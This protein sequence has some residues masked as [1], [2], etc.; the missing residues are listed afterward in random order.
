MRSSYGSVKPERAFTAEM[1]EELTAPF[2]LT[3]NLKLAALVDCPE[4]A[5]TPLMSL[6]FTEREL[7][8]S[9]IRNPIDTGGGL[10]AVNAELSITLDVSR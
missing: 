10:T 8:T 1:S 3:S 5:F 7:F 6:E 2:A 4:R 9:P